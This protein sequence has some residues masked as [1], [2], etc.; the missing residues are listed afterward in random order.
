MMLQRARAY[1]LS[2][3]PIDTPLAARG[4]FGCNCYSSGETTHLERVMPM[5]YKSILTF[6]TMAA[7]IPGYEEVEEPELI[8]REGEVNELSMNCPTVEN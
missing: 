3:Q 4:D 7:E 2:D 8:Q 5:A 1:L 6:F